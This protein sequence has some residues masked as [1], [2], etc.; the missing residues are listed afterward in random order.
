VI[1]VARPLLKEFTENLLGEEGVS[2]QDCEHALLEIA[3]VVCGNVLPELASIDAEFRLES[4]ELCQAACFDRHDPPL[5][6]TFIDHG[7]IMVRLFRGLA[8]DAELS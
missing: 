4:P 6:E 3:N 8:R 2:Q 1:G 7:A 5:A